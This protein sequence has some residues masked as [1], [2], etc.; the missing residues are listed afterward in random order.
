[1]SISPRCRWCGSITTA[2]PAG[3]MASA[4]NCSGLPN[5]QWRNPIVPQFRQ[6]MSNWIRPPSSV[7]RRAAS[8]AAA[9]ARSRLCVT[10]DTTCS[11]ATVTA[12]V[13]ASGP[14]HTT[15]KS[16]PCARATAC[17]VFQIVVA[18]TSPSVADEPGARCRVATDSAIAFDEGGHCESMLNT[19]CAQ[20]A[21][22]GS[23]SER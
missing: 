21:A 22:A 14:R 4:R 18:V 12:H 10:P 19:C 3:G 16:H 7:W 8:S 11:P 2:V 17:R 5:A 20:V 9:C 13:Q 23:W 6:N 1:M 15:A